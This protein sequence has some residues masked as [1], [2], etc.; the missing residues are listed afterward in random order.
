VRA[1]LAL[2][3]IHGQERPDRRPARQAGP[4]SAEF[5]T[6]LKSAR[7]GLAGF[8]KLAAIGLAAAATAAAAGVAMGVAVKSAIDHFDELAKTSARIAVAVGTTFGAPV[9]RADL[10]RG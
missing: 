6:G 3:A 1:A 7:T 2:G 9:R 5:E 4:G 8:G 10:F